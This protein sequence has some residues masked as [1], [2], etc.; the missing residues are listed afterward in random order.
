MHKFI[1]LCRQWFLRRPIAVL[2]L[3][4][5]LACTQSQSQQTQGAINGSVTDPSGAV[6]PGATVTLTNTDEGRVRSTKTSGIGEYS[7]MDVVAGRYSLTVSMPGF[8]RW[9]VSGVVLA[10]RQELRLDAKLTVGAVK[11]EISVNADQINTI[12]KESPTLSGTFT[13]ADVISLPVNTRASGS[14]TS[15]ASILGFLPGVQNDSSGFSLMGAL[16]FQTDITVDG[17]TTRSAAGGAGYLPNAFPST[18]SISN[19]RADGILAGA[20]YADPA[21]IVVTSKAG[22]NTLHGSGFIYSQSDLFNAIAYHYPTTTVK[23]LV[24]GTTFGASLGGAVVIPH[25]YNGHN[26]TFFFG[27]YEGWRHPSQTTINE[28]VPSTLM[29]TGNFSKYTSTVW[30]AGGLTDPYTGASWGTAIPSTAISAIAANA[31]TTFYPDP[32]IGDPT[33][34]TDNGTANYHANVDNSAHSNQFDIRGDQYFGANQKF[35]VWGKYTWK[36]FP[37]TN[38]EILKVPSSTTLNKS[39]VLRIDTNWTIKPKLINTGGF[40]FSRYISGS[41]DSFDG[42]AWTLAQGWVG[43][44]NLYYNGIPQMAFNHIQNLNA[45][46][47]DGPSR[48]FTYDYF[49]ELL[50]TKGRHTAKAGGEF[51]HLET[52][53]GLSFNG[54]D[55][56]GT[57]TFNNSNSKGLF[58]GVDFADFLL[59][60]PYETFY[61]VVQEDNDGLSQYF[62]FYAQDEWR[63]NPRLTITAGVRYELH[64]S[65]HDRY[66]DIG[67]FDPSVALSGEALYS[68]GMESKLA[69]N[70]LTSANACDPDGLR[71][72]NSATINGAPC[73][74]V[75]SSSTAN[76]PDGL[77]T[78]PKRILVPR[79]GFAYR[80]LANNDKWVLRSGFAI[81]DDTVGGSTF[82]GMTGTLQSYSQQYINT[83]NPTTY[84]IGYQWPAI[85][86][87]ATAKGFTPAYGSD[88]F[89]TSAAV[90]WR[91][92]YT[93]QWDLTV[94][95]DFGSGYAGRISYIGS[96]S[97]ELQWAP[98]YNTLPFSST[99]SAYNQPASARRFP[100]WGRV[101]TYIPGGNQRYE[102]LQLSASH[103][104]QHGLEF[105]SDFA[106]TKN[107]CDNQGISPTQ[108]AGETGVGR[109]TSILDRHADF[110]DV[111]GTRRLRWNTTGVYDLPIGRGKMFGSGMS[112]AA[113]M[114]VGGWN[115]SYILL[116]QTGDYLTPYFSSGQGDPSGTGSGLTS[117]K[118][119]WD[120]SHNNQHPDRV[121]GVSPVPIGGARTRLNWVNSGAYTCPGNPAWTVGTSC[122]TGSGSGAVPLPIGR[123]GNATE[124]NLEGP[125]MFNLSSG[126]RKTIP[127]HDRF[128]ISLEGTFTNVLNHTNLGNPNLSLSSTSF[129]QITS[130]NTSD[131]GGPR[132][133]QVS[134]RVDF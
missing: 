49:D 65:Y 92:P 7:F 35:L 90:N 93:E 67:N 127:V 104:L 10:V 128:K 88:Y 129:G 40:S 41:Y 24:T 76:V 2:G 60:L 27:T 100:N 36:N 122:T 98:D 97:H 42:H 28:V 62:E 15:A 30:P 119:G 68:Q 6:L 99:V 59:G 118:A 109:S 66:G 108:F 81:Y 111:Y 51:K 26:K 22:T 23:P 75:L 19:I 71:T 11:Q 39:E 96:A 58:S 114:I 18:E 50:W 55:N 103:R 70:F 16:P 32:N 57:Y 121:A 31:L 120:P 87:A 74:P 1:D 133:G 34:Y 63:F 79:L 95:H 132:T 110:G 131:L 54:A 46:R 125:H 113:D 56:Y 20:E 91:D 78:T 80:P 69:Q 107:L 33:A 123:F 134:L 17:V 130:A 105:H 72:T 25:Y 37:T 83:Y 8:E 101:Y 61:D 29:K 124:G 85:D 38:A 47:L 89:G 3:L 9:S 21:Q 117:S 86:A 116:W 4:L 82:Y 13:S 94:D 52:I 53:S 12:E 43:L 126:L 102:S 73:M 106:W 5:L 112:R 45:D 48:S 115:L 84:A 77:R 14:G 44:Q 64:P